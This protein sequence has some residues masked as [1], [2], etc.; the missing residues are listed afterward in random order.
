MNASQTRIAHDRELP[1]SP[2]D[3]SGATT[4]G[5]DRQSGQNISN[6]GGD[7]TIY[8]GERNRPVRA[9][10][11]LAAF[12]L[13]LSLVGLA[14]LVVF[15]VMTAHTVLHAANNGGV[16]KPYTQYVPSAWPGVVG[17]LLSGFV[18][19]RVARILVGR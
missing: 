5:I 6:I 3:A 13:L 14:L 7:Q 18:V 16:E 1:G 11:V 2:V 19:N 10:K 4:F 17:L 12:G 15:G 9:G 8:Y